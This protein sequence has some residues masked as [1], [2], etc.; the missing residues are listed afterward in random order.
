MELTLTVI[1]LTNTATVLTLSVIVLTLTMTVLTLSV[2]E[3]NRHPAK[4]AGLGGTGKGMKMPDS[5]LAEPGLPLHYICRPVIQDELS[6]A[7]FR[8][9]P[10]YQPWLREI[11]RKPPTAQKHTQTPEISHL[12]VQ[13][14]A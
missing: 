10:A 3:D 5:P 14:S 8:R 6:S 9:T 7:H 11:V 4:I 2:H 13:N 1:V 12:Q